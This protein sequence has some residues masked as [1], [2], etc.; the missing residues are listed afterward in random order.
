MIV[1]E[2]EIYR[3]FSSIPKTK[4]KK[5]KSEDSVLNY[6]IYWNSENPYKT[7]KDFKIL[8]I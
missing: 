1:V 6:I 7:I 8:L 5:F 4:I 2:F 3:C